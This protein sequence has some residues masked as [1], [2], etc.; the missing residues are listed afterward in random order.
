ML[1]FNT[2]L[3][4]ITD[5]DAY[6]ICV[7]NTDEK[8]VEAINHCK[9]HQ[10]MNRSGSSVVASIDQQG[11]IDQGGIYHH[12]TVRTSSCSIVVNGKDKCFNCAQYCNNLRSIY[13]RYRNKLQHSSSSISRA[14]TIRYL[15]TPQRRKTIMKLRQKNL[16]LK[17]RMATMKNQI[18]KSTTANGVDITC[19]QLRSDMV[20][21][22]DEFNDDIKSHPNGSFHRVF[23]EQHYNSITKN[24]RRQIRWHPAMIKWCL[25][26]KYLSSSC[27][28]ALRSSN[29]IQLPSE[30]TLRDYSNW[31]KATTG[32]SVDVDQQILSEANLEN[33]PDYH[34]YICIAMDECKI[35]EDLI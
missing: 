21:I 6:N 20:N 22:M 2:I 32:F 19:D 11:V 26:L 7:G 28:N 31:T 35:K 29:V 15:T 10:I 3:D 12:V 33:S 9:N 1:D 18:E 17:R 16:L 13:S 30:R 5:I 34:R 4:L 14:T 25:S 27:Y 24:N 8:F 23:W